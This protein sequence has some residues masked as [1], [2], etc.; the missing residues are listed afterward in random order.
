[1]RVAFIEDILRFS[2]PLGITGIGAMLR[3]A[4]HEVEVFVANKLEKTLSEVKA[5]APDVVAFSVI[6]GCH[7]GYYAIARAVKDLLGV[8]TMWGGPHPTFFPEMIE[9]PWVDAVCIGEGE[10]AVLKFA[11]AFDAENVRLKRSE[12]FCPQGYAEIK[13]TDCLEPFVITIKG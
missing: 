5:Y 12:K 8:P 3:E 13:I 4:G 1:M 10:E 9:L 11:D 2:I 7:Q 6:S